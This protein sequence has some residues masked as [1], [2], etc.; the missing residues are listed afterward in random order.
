VITVAV[1]LV[2]WSALAVF[3]MRRP[4]GPADPAWD[5]LS[6]TSGGRLVAT[7]A[8][9]LS[10]TFVVR[11]NIERDVLPDLQPMLT[12]TGRY[13]GSVEVFWSAQVLSFLASASIGSTVMFGS[14]H[15]F[16]RFM[17][18]SIALIIGM[19][20][21]MSLRNTFRERIAAVSAD[22]PDFGELLLLILPEMVVK[23]ALTHCATH[24]E[25]PVAEEM[26]RL[27][28]QLSVW[29]DDEQRLFTA[30]AERLGP[31]EAFTFLSSLYTSYIENTKLVGALAAQ[32]E[33]M[34][35]VQYQRR[36][37]EMKKMPTSMVYIFAL[38]FMPL[39][40]IL[41]FLPVVVGLARGV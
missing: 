11:R 5:R 31:R 27:V 39:L 38:H 10:S 30:S 32:V 37:A 24:A 16:W 35:R 13:G 29:S 20:P 8:R 23:A 6:M 25:G 36:R 1:L 28:R 15:W 19:L 22:L 34:R 17:L 21:Y 18:G 3:A 26:Q 2:F 41:S 9:P 4:A 14:L 33:T 7:L 12:A 40:F